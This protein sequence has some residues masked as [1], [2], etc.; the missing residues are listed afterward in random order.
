MGC[1]VLGTLQQKLPDM[2]HEGKDRHVGIAVLDW[3][4]SLVQ[5][6]FTDLTSQ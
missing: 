4:Q 1:C 6:S 5:D 2:I 3:T